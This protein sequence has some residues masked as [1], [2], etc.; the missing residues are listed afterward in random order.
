MTLWGS[1]VDAS[2]STPYVLRNAEDDPF[3]PPPPEPVEEPEPTTTEASTTKS[4]MRPTVIHS[5]TLGDTAPTQAQGAYID[6]SHERA[7]LILSIVGFVTF[8]LLLGGL[9]FLVV[10]RK[11]MLRRQSAYA[12]VPVT[13]DLR[14]GSLDVT[15]QQPTHVLY[16]EDEETGLIAAHEHAESS[17]DVP[18]SSRAEDMHQDGNVP[19]D[20]YT[21][22]E[23]SSRQ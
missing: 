15:R 4:Y 21:D 7:Q 5:A 16:D 19:V 13:E 20:R 23:T 2:K 22:N 3:P 8:F 17:E 6:D 10:R 9:V 11:R 18:S 14:L 1:S 12:S